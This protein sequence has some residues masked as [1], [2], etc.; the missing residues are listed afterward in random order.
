MSEVLRLVI[1]I[2]RTDIDVLTATADPATGHHRTFCAKL[3]CGAS[4]SFHVAIPRPFAEARSLWLANDAGGF[5][6]GS[7]KKRNLHD[8]IGAGGCDDRLRYESR[9][10]P[11]IGVVTQSRLAGG[12]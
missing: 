11:S 9:T 2:A 3:G 12:E 8:R 10:A 7:D 4:A 6:C 1:D 5:T